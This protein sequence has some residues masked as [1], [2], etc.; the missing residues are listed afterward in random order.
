M[1]WAPRAEVKFPGFPIE[2]NCNLSTGV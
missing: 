2:L 1:F